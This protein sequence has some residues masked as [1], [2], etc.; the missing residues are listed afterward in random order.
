MYCEL[1]V[2]LVNILFSL[3]N[4]DICFHVCKEVENYDNYVNNMRN[5]IRIYLQH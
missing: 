5:E 4:A 1:L 2:T 3:I